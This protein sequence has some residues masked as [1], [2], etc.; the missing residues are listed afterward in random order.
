MIVSRQESRICASLRSWE[1]LDMIELLV[2]YE[3]VF[4]LHI[5]IQK[6]G[7]QKTYQGVHTFL[8]EIQQHKVHHLVHG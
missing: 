1:K 3:V 8:G 6:K 4:V 5:M 7:S 2:F